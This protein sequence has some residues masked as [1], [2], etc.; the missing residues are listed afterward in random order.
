MLDIETTLVTLIE[1][2]SYMMSA[3]SAAV[4]D[5]AERVAASASASAFTP[6]SRETGTGPLLLTAA[7]NAAH[8]AA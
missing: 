7:T 1:I 6:S 3:I 4:P 5:F 2:P 8:S